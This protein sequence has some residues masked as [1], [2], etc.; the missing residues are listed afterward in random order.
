MFTEF[1]AAEKAWNVLKRSDQTPERRE[2]IERQLNE[3]LDLIQ[4]R[5]SGPIQAPKGTFGVEAVFRE[6][7]LASQ[8]E[9]SAVAEYLH[10]NRH[11][12]SSISIIFTD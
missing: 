3:K 9:S 11:K 12:I 10:W 2:Q 8:S 5:Y 1:R 4:R 7:T 6:G